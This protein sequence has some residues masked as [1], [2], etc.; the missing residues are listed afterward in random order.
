MS[1]G[2]IYLRS[3]REDGLEDWWR[4]PLK[5]CE[6]GRARRLVARSAHL[7]DDALKGRSPAGPRCTLRSGD[8][9]AATFACPDGSRLLANRQIAVGLPN[10]P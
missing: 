7:E 5:K 2:G 3:V 6:G 4:V 1:G 8:N 10:W 9:R